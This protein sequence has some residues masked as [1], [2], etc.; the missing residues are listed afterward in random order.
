MWAHGS[1][2]R[3][4]C[5]PLSGSKALEVTSKNATQRLGIGGQSL[6]NLSS[7][8]NFPSSYHHPFG[9]T[10]IFYIYN[11]LIFVFPTLLYSKFC[12]ST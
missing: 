10:G 5:G 3:C 1:R 9:Y 2:V 6:S 11:D 12:N 4:G 7:G 8:Y